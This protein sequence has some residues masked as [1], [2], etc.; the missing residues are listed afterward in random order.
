MSVAIDFGVLHSIIQQ[1]DMCSTRK[2]ELPSLAC[3]W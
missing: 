2:T 1:S 3:R